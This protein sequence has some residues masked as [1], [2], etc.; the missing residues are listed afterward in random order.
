MGSNKIFPDKKQKIEIMNIE[1]TSSTFYKIF[2][3]NPTKLEVKERYEK[4]FFYN[5]ITEQRGYKILNF[6]SSKNYQYYLTDINA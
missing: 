1:V 5:E 6:A 3:E 4:S 2:E